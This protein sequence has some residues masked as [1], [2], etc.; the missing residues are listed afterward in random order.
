MKVKGI[1]A[2]YTSK[3]TSPP[4]DLWL[5]STFEFTYLNHGKD[6]LLQH[7]TLHQVVRSA[8]VALA[9]DDESF[10]QPNDIHCKL[11]NTFFLLQDI[12]MLLM[13]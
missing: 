11:I 6:Q 4:L 7:I 9:A 8:L 3:P 1:L 12:F 5:I 13:T 10:F 2:T